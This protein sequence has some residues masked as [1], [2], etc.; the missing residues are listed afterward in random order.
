MGTSFGSAS[1]WK[2]LLGQRDLTDR[3]FRTENFVDRALG[4]ESPVSVPENTGASDIRWTAVVKDEDP[5]PPRPTDDLPSWPTEDFPGQG[6][7]ITFLTGIFARAFPGAGVLP[8]GEELDEPCPPGQLYAA[9]KSYTKK[10]LVYSH[11]AA[12]NS[13]ANNHPSFMIQAF[14]HGFWKFLAVSL[15]YR[16]INGVW[17]PIPVPKFGRGGDGTIKP[18]WVADGTF[19]RNDAQSLLKGM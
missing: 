9:A 17:L 16:R 6:E 7:F 13:P 14:R 18:K 4:N 10:L 8:A 12:F 3:Q 5:T 2:K 15:L 11:D 19:L 1:D